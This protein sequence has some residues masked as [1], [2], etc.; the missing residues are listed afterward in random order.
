MQRCNADNAT[1]ANG[2]T[3]AEGIVSIL[4]SFKLLRNPCSLF[5][6]GLSLPAGIWPAQAGTVIPGFCEERNLHLSG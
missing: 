5:R 2:H 1:D 4:D 3:V 6:R